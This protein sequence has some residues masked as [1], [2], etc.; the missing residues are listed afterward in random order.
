MR[1]IEQEGSR[2]SILETVERELRQRFGRSHPPEE[3]RQA[4]TV[5]VD[6]V[7][8]KGVRVKAFVPVLAGRR[9]RRRLQS[10]NR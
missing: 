6:E 4:A 3:I 2:E 10:T 9:A 5:S 8:G 1:S 7:L